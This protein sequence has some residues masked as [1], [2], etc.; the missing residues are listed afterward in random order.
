MKDFFV[1]KIMDIFKWI[2]KAFGI[3]YNVVR[4]IV[5]SKLLMDSRRVGN[6]V[7]IDE[8]S[9]KEKNYYLNSLI[10]YGII[11]LSSLPIMLLD[12]EPIIKMSFYFGFFMIMIL[13]SFISDFSTVILDINDKDIIGTKGVDLKTLNAA[14][15][16][17]IFIY[18]SMLSMAISG[19]GLIV[20]LRYGFDFFLLFIISILL[21][22][23][24]MI[25]VTASMYFVIIKLFSGEKLKDMLNIFQIIFLLIFTLGYQVVAQSFKVID[26]NIIYNPKW[27]NILLPPM[28]FASN[29]SILKGVNLNK[30][31]IVLSILSI[32]I[33]LI[34][35]VIYIKLVPKFESSLQKLNDNTY[36]NRRVNETFTYKVSKLICR[37]K[38]ERIFFNFV[39]NILS[40]DREFKTKVYPSLAIGAFMP[41]LIIIMSYDKSGINQYLSYL[42]ESSLFFSAYMSIIISQNVINM[43]QYSTEYEACWIY[44]VIPIK[45]IANIYLGMFKAVIYKLVLGVFSIIYIG[46][47]FIFK[48]SVLKHL[49]V[50]FLVNIIVSMV[51]FMW[52]EVQFPF[53]VKYQ[54]ATSISSIGSVLKSM[55]VV[56]ILA[57][58]H[59]LVSEN[60]LFIM[61][62]TIILCIT[63][64]LYW[65]KFKK[66][67]NKK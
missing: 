46:F 39:N 18:I 50:M 10:I 20:S 47:L 60:N 29:F 36:K 53:S 59:F 63:I 57:G 61:L 23:I 31:L 13:T 11:G 51:V 35:I 65:R 14:K 64:Y 26:L 34:S 49:V 7:S 4:L 8:E 32:I 6:I 67:I 45:N 15:I 2:Y 43:I 9:G 41:F 44:E 12:T 66:I 24:F 19:G 48:I 38:E 56:G 33:P 17:H 21:I 37:D 30:I 27:W 40:K 25:I 22:D 3:N 58:I 62:Y 52:N 5:Q 42:K 1:L 28:W 16:T 54:T 55:F